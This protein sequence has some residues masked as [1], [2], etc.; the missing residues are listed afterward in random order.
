M[1][2][3]IYNDDDGYEMIPREETSYQ[4]INF[5]KNDEDKIKYKSNISNI[6]D[7][8]SIDK[9]LE[10]LDSVCYGNRIWMFNLVES[11][12]IKNVRINKNNTKTIGETYLLLPEY[13][14]KSKKIEYIMFNND[15]LH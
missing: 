11:S 13:N 15:E 7:V 5:Y 9:L 6:K 10:E 3:I 8:K 4:Y 2:N 12:Q 1:E 14:M